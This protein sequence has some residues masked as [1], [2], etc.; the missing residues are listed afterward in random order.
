MFQNQLPGA[1]GGRDCPQ[2]AIGE[3]IDGFTAP[4]TFVPELWGL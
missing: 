2:A 4:M 3:V 1:P